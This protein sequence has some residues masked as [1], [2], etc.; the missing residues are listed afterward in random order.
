MRTRTFLQV[1][2]VSVVLAA[3]ASGAAVAAQPDTDAFGP[4][5]RAEALRVD[6]R[7]ARERDAAFRAEST[8]AGWSR[9]AAAALRRAW[10]AAERQ[11]VTVRAIECR[12][13]TCRVEV[14][15]QSSGELN[16]MLPGV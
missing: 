15:P 5:A 10:N 3:A 1:A 2:T 14:V 8:E 16:D 12:S 7:Q 9:A 13:R 4:A 11:A 6:R